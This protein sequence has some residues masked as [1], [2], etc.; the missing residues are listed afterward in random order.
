M[1]PSMPGRD[2]KL[3]LLVAEECSTVWIDLV[4]L[5]GSSVDWRLFLLSGYSELF[6]GHS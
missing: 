5:I 6:S 1:G 2:S 4:L 3:T